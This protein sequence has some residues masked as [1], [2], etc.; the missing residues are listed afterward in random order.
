MLLLP[1]LEDTLRGMEMLIMVSN[2]MDD[3]ATK[4][5]DLKPGSHRTKRT[6]QTDNVRT[7]ADS[8]LLQ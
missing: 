8:L 1:A 2:R 3:S 6:M 4:R 7:D 5:N